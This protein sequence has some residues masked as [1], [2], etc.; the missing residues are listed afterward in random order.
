VPRVSV[1]FHVSQ[2]RAAPSTEVIAVGGEVDIFTAPDV[3]RAAVAAIDDGVKYIVLD[4]LQTTFLDST[5]LGVIIGLSK[6]V[7]PG[8]G[9][10]IIVN[11]DEGIARTFEITGLAEIFRIYT[12][13]EEALSAAAEA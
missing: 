12:T 6:R 2:E 11:T 13:R 9:D 4:L 5:G 3:R 10:V 7:R 8:G 1:Q